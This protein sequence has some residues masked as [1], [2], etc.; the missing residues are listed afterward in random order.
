M[1][2]QDLNNLL[3]AAQALLNDIKAMRQ[4]DSSWYGPF[5]NFT[6]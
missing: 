2:D 1:N 4:E 5:I 3:T 6:D